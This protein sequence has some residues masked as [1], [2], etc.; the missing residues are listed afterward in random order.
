M[1]GVVVIFLLYVLT[2]LA[3]D[4]NGLI[5]TG[6]WALIGAVILAWVLTGTRKDA[7]TFA[8]IAD[9][10]RS[11]LEKNE[12]LAYDIRST[13]FAELE[14]IEDEGAC[15]AFQI[16]DDRMVFLS[17]QQFYP[18]A[19][20]PSHDFSIVHVLDEHDNAVAEHI[21]K[22]GPQVEAS[23]FVPA[24]VKARL[25]IPDDLDVVDG[26]I[27]DIEDLFRKPDPTEPA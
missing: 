22:R 17:G 25:E 3:S 23:E 24:F 4:T 5:V 20:F 1:L 14:E 7:R 27:E 18:E 9:A 10:Y 16:E 15:Y 21:E 8:G 26:R 12:V 13:A 6:F 2:L 19:K 11:A